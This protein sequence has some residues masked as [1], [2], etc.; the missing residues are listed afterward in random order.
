MTERPL[1]AQTQTPLTERLLSLIA[2]NGPISVGD[3]IS[4]ALGHPQYGYYATRDPFGVDGDF[5]TAPEISQIFGELIGAWLVDAWETMG[6]PS[7]FQLVEL[8]PGR[9]TLMSDILRVA[10]LRPGF[11]KA[12]RIT[13]I[14]NS[15]LLRVRQQK[16]LSGAHEHLIWRTSLD[17]VP[18]G[19]LL[20][21]ANEFF[22]CLPIR[23]FVRTADQDEAPWRERLVGLNEAGSGFCFVLS[24]TRYAD[25]EGV[26]PRA[27]PEAIFETSPM[28]THIIQDFSRRLQQHKGRV[29][30]IDYGHG[31]S[32]FGD[33]FQAVKRHHYIHPLEQAGDVDVT[34]HVDFAAL[35][36]AG[37][38]A[39]VRVDGPVRQ[40]DFLGRLGFDARLDRLL[41]QAGD[42]AEDLVN[43]SRRLVDPG[44]MGDL[45]KV[46]S[47]SSPELPTPPGFA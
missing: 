42:N 11:L 13:M 19:P 14:E 16:T 20:V 10:K 43:G 23:Q 1:A 24:E 6:S 22:D 29:L 40:G 21:V 27:K 46:L 30:I 25:P 44:G 7:L 2:E 28:G 38:A 3:F 17:D 35:A 31:R 34:S 39:G 37:R 12:A 15:G 5:T 33:T 8:G 45:F 4:D 36:R 32:G 41:D 9:G 18:E 26:P 47:I